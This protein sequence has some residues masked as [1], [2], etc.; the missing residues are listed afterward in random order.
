M[1]KWGRESIKC[2]I[3]LEDRI[4]LLRGESEKLSCNFTRTVFHRNFKMQNYVHE[5]TKSFE[6]LSQLCRQKQRFLERQANKWSRNNL[7]LLSS[8]G[9]LSGNSPPRDEHDIQK[10]P[11]PL[12]WCWRY[13]ARTNGKHAELWQCFK[14]FL[15]WSFIHSLLVLVVGAVFG[16]SKNFF[17]ELFGSRRRRQKN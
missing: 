17:F 7:F 9:A 3:N 12:C 8:N 1:E 15:N 10:Q 2:E 5:I 13:Y 6:Q 4:S 14:S 11:A 16:D